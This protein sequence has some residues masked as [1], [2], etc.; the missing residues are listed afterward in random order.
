M[1]RLFESI[2]LD[3]LCFRWLVFMTII[4]ICAG[5]VT[6]LPEKVGIKDLQSNNPAVQVLAIKWAGDNK[7]QKAV[8]L[9]VDLLESQD[10]SVRFY[11]ILALKKIT[12]KTLGY[13]YA[14]DASSRAKGVENWRKFLKSETK[15]KQSPKTPSMKR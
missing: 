1:T 9:L 15:N 3:K 5:C 10:A 7:V 12:G 4:N 11:A 14:E 2:F 13:N 6:K 8:P